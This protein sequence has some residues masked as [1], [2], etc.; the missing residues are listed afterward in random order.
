[1]PEVYNP[2]HSALMV[3]LH[4]RSYTIP[5]GVSV[6]PDDVAIHVAGPQNTGGALS[7]IGVV[8]LDSAVYSQ[9]EL[10]EQALTTHIRHMERAGA[11][12]FS[13]AH[14][15]EARDRLA[16]LASEPSF[17]DEPEPAPTTG[18]IVTAKEF[19]LSIP[20]SH[21]VAKA[22]AMEPKPRRKRKKKAG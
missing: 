10:K 13:P 22:A 1:M 12:Y 20:V 16:A 3:D 11:K 7:A 4:G 5:P 8:L 21:L 9:V 14:V 18:G 19:S 17:I 15:L 6:Q 2:A